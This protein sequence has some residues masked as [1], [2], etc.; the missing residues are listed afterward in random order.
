M[1]DEKQTPIPSTGIETATIYPPIASRL[2]EW[3]KA[4]KIKQASLACELNVTQAAVSRWES[5]LDTPTPDKMARLLSLMKWNNVL[6]EIDQQFIRGL[7]S[8][9]ALFDF[10]GV[11]LLAASRGLQRFWP[12]FTTLTGTAFG[13]MLIGEA[14]NVLA[15]REITSQI[16]RGRSM[17]ITAIS[18]RHLSMDIDMPVTHRWH[19]RIRQANGNVLVEVAYEPSDPTLTPGIESIFGV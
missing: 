6:T 4:N 3:R 7:E 1:T 12:I 9:H 14:A 8:N 17:L 15:D 11:K 18:Q 2:R 10:D 5:G 13:D 16:T 19:A